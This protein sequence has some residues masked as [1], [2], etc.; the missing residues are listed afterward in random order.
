MLRQIVPNEEEIGIIDDALAQP[1]SE[2]INLPKVC[3]TN[4]F[5]IKVCSIRALLLVDGKVTEIE[6]NLRELL[7]NR[8]D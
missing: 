4:E 7:Y 6:Y 3:Y 1:L 2:V 5:D 8:E